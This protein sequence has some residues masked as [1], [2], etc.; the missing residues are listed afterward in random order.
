MSRGKFEVT[1]LQ[2]VANALGGKSC[3][4]GLTS[5]TWIEVVVL[6]EALAEAVPARTSQSVD[7][8]L[9]APLVMQINNITVS[10]LGL[11]VSLHQLNG[12]S[13]TGGRTLLE[14][15]GTHSAGRIDRQ[16]I[17]VDDRLN[18]AGIVVS[19]N[20]EALSEAIVAR[21]SKGNANAVFACLLEKVDSTLSTAG[22]FAVAFHTSDGVN[23]A[24]SRTR[25]QALGPQIARFV[26]GKGRHG[27]DV[28]IKVE[29]FAE[30]DT[31]TVVASL[32]QVFN[33]TR[34]TVLVVE[35]S[36]VTNA[37][38]AL[39]VGLH[40]IESVLGALVGALSQALLAVLLGNGHWHN[41]CGFDSWIEVTSI[42]EAVSDAVVASLSEHLNY[43]CLAVLLVEVDS[44]VVF[45]GRSAVVLHALDG[46]S[47]AI[48]GALLEAS[49]AQLLCRLLRQMA[50]GCWLGVM[51]L[52]VA[53]AL[54]EASV[55][56]LADKLVHAGFAIIIVEVNTGGLAARWLAV[57]FHSLEKIGWAGFGTEL[58]A[59]GA[60]ALGDG[61]R[62]SSLGD[63]LGIEVLLFTEAS[64]EAVPAR[65]AEST[66]GTSFALR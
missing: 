27:W 41:G 56:A 59:F 46:V 53:E 60:H 13:W 65:L 62:H 39:A 12:V 43:T 61:D 48:V 58:E 49:T 15:L 18:K 55:A 37:A 54:S 24:S 52:H 16:G 19:L 57:G 10:A 14:T 23:W 31:E 63:E 35:V 25:L 44:V 32:T 17:A 2:L 47:W 30:A 28:K 50:L 11:A 8:A 42:Y 21:I 51:V 66:D 4:L 7:D 64:A 3:D 40:D 26:S 9:V 1:C 29:H 36:S 33:D 34:F 22:G 45:A 5:E 20:G 38:L 6:A